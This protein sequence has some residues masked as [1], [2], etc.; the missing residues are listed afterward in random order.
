MSGDFLTDSQIQNYGCYSAKPNEVQLAKYFHLDERGL[1]FV[2]Q[3]WAG[4]TGLALLFSSPP[5]VFWVHF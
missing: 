1:D 5:H 3:R 2:N 4:T